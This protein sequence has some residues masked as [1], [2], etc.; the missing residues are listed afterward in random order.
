M[1]TLHWSQSNDFVHYGGAGLQMLGYDWKQDGAETGQPLIEEFRFDDDARQR[2]RSAL[3]ADVPERLSLVGRNGI[4][5]D[6]FFAGTTNEM[7]ATSEI[8]RGVMGELSREGEIKVFGRDGGLRR[9]GSIVNKSDRLVVSSQMR[10][11]PS[12]SVQRDHKT[13]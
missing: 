7:P 8:L 1:T 10:L 11:L 5:F 4:S 13:G 2:T 12:A 9:P 3:L 6:D